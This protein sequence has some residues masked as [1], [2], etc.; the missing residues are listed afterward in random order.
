MVENKKKSRWK[1]VILGIIIMMFLGTVYSYSVFRI[2]L[3]QA[4]DIGSAQSG[5]PYMTALAFYAIFMFITGRYIERFNPRTII[6]VGG[7]LVSAGWIL[8]SFATGIVTLTIAY[9]CIGGAGVG[10]AYG[11]PMA[12][13]AKWFPEKKG[14]AVGLV[15]VGFGLS[16]LIT[17]PLART[18]VELVGLTRAFLILGAGFAVFLP[19]LSYFFEYP[20][21]EAS[22]QIKEEGKSVKVSGYNTKEMIKD[23]SFKGLYINFIIGTTIGLM[24]VGM[25]TSIGVEYVG[26]TATKVTM[27]MTIFA[28][29][30]GMGRPTFGWLTDRLS[31]RKAMLLSYI[32]IISAAL[33]MILFGESNL[34]VYIIGFAIFWFNLGGWL[35][36]APASTMNMY[37]TGHYS[38]NYGLV[39]TAYGIGAV[40]GVITSGMLIDAHGNYKL[41]FYYIIAL[42][43]IGIFST[44]NFIK[45]KNA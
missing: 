37:G 21:L 13:V 6:L 15:L 33:V 7:F 34:I 27:L 24:L 35:A 18:I 3:E 31:P 36:I 5:L 1:Y 11:V 22:Y 38:Q 41:L 28:I 8:S 16:P 40:T 45:P 43:L 2:S 14:F 32:L 12:V 10:I 26:L 25:T 30:N 9:G 42:C 39:F 44:I 29:F 17:A 23:K 19:V 20:E 4:F